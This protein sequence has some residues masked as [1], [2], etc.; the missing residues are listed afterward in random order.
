MHIELQNPFISINKLD[1]THLPSFTVL[2]GKN[3]SGKTHFL[4]G[5]NQ[6]QISVEGIDKSE[7]VYYNYNDFTIID[8]RTNN[9][10]RRSQRR[11]NWNNNAKYIVQRIENVKQTAI[12]KIL[13]DSRHKPLRLL[14]I[15]II[16]LS[17]QIFFDRYGVEEDYEL[18]EEFI[19][20]GPASYSQYERKF[21]S[22]FSQFI[23]N[24]I[25]RN[26]DLN[27]ISKENFFR[28]YTEFRNEVENL[29]KIKDNELFTLLDDKLYSFN[30]GDIENPDF[31]LEDIASEE[32]A[33]QFKKATNSFNKLM[34]SEWGEDREY[35]KPKDFINRFGNSPVDQINAVLDDYDC[36]GYKLTTNDFKIQIGQE[37]N[38]QSINITL[39]HP[40]NNYTTSFDQ[41][42]SGEKT[43][44]ALSLL[45]Y[46]SKKN[47]ILPRMLLLDEIDSSL[48]PS[49]IKMLL[50]VIEKHFVGN[51]KMK[52]ILATHSPTTVALSPK[53][54]IYFIHGNKNKTIE[55]VE[56][57][58]AI[59][60][61][62][63]GFASLS[64]DESKIGIHYNIK[65]KNLPI[66]FTEGITDKIILEIAWKKLY[67]ET[68]PFFIQDCFDASFLGNLYRRADDSQDGIFSNYPNKIFISLFDFD[69]AGYDIW[70]GLSKKNYTLLEKD[71]K[72]CLTIKHKSRQAYSLLLPVPKNDKILKQVIKSNNETYKNESALQIE[73]LMYGADSLKTFFKIEGIKG[74]GKLIVFKGNKRDFSNSLE[75]VEAD[76][77]SNFTPLFQK[78]KEII[79][80]E[81]NIHA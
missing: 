17:K 66:V 13:Q 39:E 8:S 76:D 23:K 45:I 14:M 26:L 34:N 50:N 78:I 56:M 6:G 12:N 11:S 18:L 42:S 3:G 2:T 32:R 43:L 72:K 10:Q 30:Q 71:P 16:S 67:K 63:E 20:N 40:N 79:S 19:K 24:S 64:I 22:Y 47:K 49:K 73:L 29:I 5:I 61:L 31:F 36:N 27:L 51:Q 37:K 75:N 41:I 35:I 21:S 58:V 53:K 60:T 70:N 65:N 48:H 9:D 69:K 46:K 25:S 38:S 15:N 57:S 68:M 1:D 7:I 28:E 59:Q 44:I 55:N 33:Y 52:V 4:K 74:G 81:S 54:S 80:L 77:F 62:T